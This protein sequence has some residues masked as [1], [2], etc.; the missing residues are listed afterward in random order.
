MILRGGS[1]RPPATR[2]GLTALF[3]LFGV[4][5][6]TGQALAFREFF[7]YAGGGEMAIAATLAAWLGG[8]A[9]GSRLAGRPRPGDPGRQLGQATIALGLQLPA[10]LIAARL[11]PLFD[12]LPPGMT[13]DPGRTLIFAALLMGP[14]GGVVGTLLPLGS[15]IPVTGPGDPSRIGLYA[16]EGG[17]ACLGGALLTWFLLGRFPPLSILA[18]L[19]APTLLLLGR[20]VRTRRVAISCGLVGAALFIS[21]WL[22][23]GS[24]LADRQLERL[25]LQATS[26]GQMLAVHDTPQAHLVLGVDRG[27]STLYVNGQPLVF[28][29]GD[30]AVLEEAFLLTVQADRPVRVL[31]FGM[32]GLTLA[33]PLRELGAQRVTVVPG[34][35]T[36]VAQARQSLGWGIS[37]FPA[38]I[39]V[40]PGD[41]RRWLTQAGK[42]PMVFD[43]AVLPDA[44][45]GSLLEGRL[46]TREFLAALR[47]CLSPRGIVALGLPAQEGHQPP[48]LSSYQA[49]LFGTFGTVFPRRLIA[50][51]SR[52]RLLAGGPGASLTPDPA[53]LRLRAAALGTVGQALAPLLPAAFPAPDTIEFTARTRS[54]AGRQPLHT[55]DRPVAVNRYLRVTSQYGHPLFADAV[56]GVMGLP[57]GVFLLILIAPL[58][59]SFRRRDRTSPFRLPAAAILYAGG[60]SALACEM[61]IVYRFQCSL[62]TLY[63]S[64]AMLI[65]LFMGGSPLGVWLVHRRGA[66]R[67]SSFCAVGLC[68]SLALSILLFPGAIEA[69]SPWPRLEEALLYTFMAFTGAISGALYACLALRLARAGATPDAIAGR[70]NAA[71]YAGGLVGT[72]LCG[73]ILLPIFGLTATTR[74]MALPPAVAALLLLRHRNLV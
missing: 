32:A 13:G 53:T 39:E 1:S 38:G 24:G 26:P 17:G 19:L 59:P 18:L 66:P 73:S 36:L 5:T 12:G 67:A 21:V 47:R 31:I 70:L 22:P 69:A 63:R 33:A 15:R 43:L 2:A 46:Y 37:G 4:L 9:I 23:Q 72:L 57:Y 68:G 58:L 74:L 35:R 6:T 55:D 71:D 56:A 50:P 20:V 29:P 30:P 52:A 25:R 64:L 41:P 42:T 54:L 28:T 27:Q 60:C 34:D 65:A 16:A 45:T 10:T 48:V 62:G 40:V 3:V 7:I 44:E 11:L 8:V 61:L 49:V 14:V 51:G